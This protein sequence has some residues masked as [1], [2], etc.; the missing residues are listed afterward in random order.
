MEKSRILLTLLSLSLLLVPILFNTVGTNEG[1]EVVEHSENL[2]K[3]QEN[4]LYASEALN[5]AFGFDEDGYVQ[6]PSDFAGM[7]IEDE[8]LI[9]SLTNIS[10][11]SISRYRD[12]AGEYK[13]YLQFKEAQYS[14]SELNQAAALAVSEL[15]DLPDVKVLEYYVSE[16]SNTIMIGVDEESYKVIESFPSA[17]AC[18]YPIKFE[19]ADYTMP[20]ASISGGDRIRNNGSFE[21]LTLSC[22]GTYEG[23]KAALS[24]GHVNQH[25]GD[26]IYHVGLQKVVGDVVYHRFNNGTGDY[27]IISITDP[28]V[29]TSAVIAESYIVK[30]TISDAPTNT[31]VKFYG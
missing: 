5:Q 13:D 28:Y 15:N 29:S 21:Y 12:W 17:I 16:T 14:Y 8:N 27:E 25:L 11:D 2:S 23:S 7:W 26:E 4:A 9:I 24:C 20:T 6:Y 22:T 19:I 31:V 30:S 10:E 18:D 3:A 1:E